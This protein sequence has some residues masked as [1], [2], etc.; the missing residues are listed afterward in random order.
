MQ[1]FNLKLQGFKKEN[2]GFVILFAVMISSIVLAIAMGVANVAFKELKFGTSVK[3]G[4]DA[5]FATDT[6]LE[7]ALANDKTTSFSFTQSGSTGTVQ[8]VGRNIPLT[9]SYPNWT[10]VI[11]GLG[12]GGQSCAKV[13]V[14]KI[15]GSTVRTNVISKGYNDGG[16]VE[17]FCT[18]GANSVERVLELN[19]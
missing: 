5:F 15:P 4:N 16:T 7:C 1:I 9:G 17:G 6:G 3:A 14:T 13:T 19:Y 18:Q 8:C 12:S 2:K 10:F 11:S